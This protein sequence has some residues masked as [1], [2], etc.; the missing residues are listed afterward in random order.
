MYKRLFTYSINSI[1]IIIFGLIY[2]INLFLNFLSFE[3]GYIFLINIIC[4]VILFFCG[5][6]CTRS[7]FNYI[8]SIKEELIQKE[9]VV[10]LK[11]FVETKNTI[12]YIFVLILFTLSIS[13]FVQSKLN[14]QFS[15]QDFSLILGIV[16]L[17][18][19]GSIID[20]PYLGRLGYK[21]YILKTPAYSLENVT[22]ISKD[23]SIDDQGQIVKLVRFDNGCFFEV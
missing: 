23:M 21:I 19:T 17:Y 20:N 18:W 12:N 14:F 6:Y 10:E 3:A 5:L 2:F 13:E 22:V 7:V 16:G 1:P 4:A 9:C 8:N 15:I 11:H